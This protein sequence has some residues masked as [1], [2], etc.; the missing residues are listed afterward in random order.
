MDDSGS[1]SGFSKWGFWIDGRLVDGLRVT[2][3]VWRRVLWLLVPLALQVV[4]FK[5][6]K[7][8]VLQREGGQAV[9]QDK[10]VTSLFIEHAPLPLLLGG[11]AFCLAA[12]LLMR[13]PSLTTAF[14]PLFLLFFAGAAGLLRY[15]LSFRMKWLSGAFFEVVRGDLLLVFILATVALLVIHNSRG[16]V[17]AWS[18]GLLHVITLVLMVLASMDFGYF[19]MTGS[20]A[21]AYLLKYSLSNISDLSFAMSHELSGPKLVF[22]IFPFLVVAAPVLVERL[23]ARRRDRRRRGVGTVAFPALLLLVLPHFA[24]PPDVEPITG[25]TFGQ[26][27]RDF[28]S[29]PVWESDAVARPAAAD[30]PLFDTRRLRFVPTE[31]VRRMNVVLIILESMRARSVTPYEPALDTTP[32]LDSLARRSLLVEHMYAVVPHTNKA[33]TPILCGIYPEINQGEQARVPGA[34]LPRLLEPFGYASAFFTPARLDFERKD[35][36]LAEMGFEETFGDGDYSEEGFS[37]VNYFGSEDRIM[38]GPSLAWVDRQRAAGKPFLLT[39]LTLTSHHPYQT[40]TSFERRTFTKD[41]PDLNAYLNTLA[42]TDAFLADLFAAFEARGLVE[43]TIF[44]IMGDHGEAF[45]EH[46][47]RFHSAVIW[48]EGLRVPALIFSPALFPEGERISGPRQQTDV[49]PTVAEALGFSLEG[50]PAPGR[51]LLEPVP[52]ARKLYH[53]GWIENQSMAVREGTKKFIYHYRRR[54]M[55]VYD[56]A[57]DPYERRN[58]AGQYPEERLEAVEMELL[59][60]RKRVNDLYRTLRDAR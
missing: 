11:L 13:W 47:R 21:D 41:D 40:P 10:L 48:D 25:S 38:M 1:G 53:A 32:F 60:W 51:S 37:R 45:A 29:E 43:E 33:L 2:R 59:L 31:D 44:V 35:A 4:L 28:F 36:M 20:L 39:Y 23:S 19:V 49:L 56:V 6:I 54:P 15:L 26:L 30:A 14:V 50:G 7:Y 27:V 9:A 58:L 57:E 52:A 24:T 46:G 3:A 18:I 16:R 42:Y 8:A 5:L 55:E 12:F 22:L 17:R 34:C